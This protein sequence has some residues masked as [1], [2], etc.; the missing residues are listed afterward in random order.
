LVG[1]DD[2]NVRE[3]LQAANGIMN[4]IRKIF[5]NPLTRLNPL[6]HR[7]TRALEATID[8]FAS[9][10]FDQITRRENLKER[11]DFMSIL[12]NDEVFKT[13]ET[14]F[15]S[16]RMFIYA[17]SDTISRQ[18]SA[19]LTLLAKN[20]KSQQKLFEELSGC[21][22]YKTC[23]YLRAV[24]Q[25]GMRH[26]NTAPVGTLRIIGKAV[27]LEGV[28]TIPKGT[29]LSWPALPFNRN[30]ELYPNPEVFDPERFIDP[31]ADQDAGFAIWGNGV[32]DCIGRHLAK[33][34][35]TEVIGEIVKRVELSLPEGWEPDWQQKLSLEVKGGVPMIL[36]KR[37]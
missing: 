36:K 7:K 21:D 32:R 24:I 17:G 37:P 22:D 10:R 8:K 25:E 27:E 33:V 34:Q 3:L 20:P 28:G 15:N 13:R 29:T 31:K 30:P 5:G 11:Y 9:A 18:I 35:M 19:I 23:N 16:L 2:A 12:Y 4:Y 1:S 14:M 26:T 6:E